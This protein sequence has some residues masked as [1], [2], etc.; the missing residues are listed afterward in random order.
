[1]SLGDGLVIRLV[2]LIKAEVTARQIIFAYL[3]MLPIKIISNVFC[4]SA[5]K[6]LIA[7]GGGGVDGPAS[8]AITFGSYRRANGQDCC[9][10]QSVQI[11]VIFRQLRYLSSGPTQL[12][13]SRGF[14]PKV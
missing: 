13:I 6:R 1:M 10:L 2:F 5:K 8:V 14:R 3:S 9:S 4:L 12:L 11:A 7:Q